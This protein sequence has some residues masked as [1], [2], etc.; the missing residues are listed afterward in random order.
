MGISATDWLALSQMVEVLKP[1]L[2]TT[3]ILCGYM[4]S[5]GQVIPLIHALDASLETAV[6]PG[7]SLLP[8]TRALVKRLQAGLQKRLHPVYSD[9]AYRMPCLCDP[10]IKGRLGSTHLKPQ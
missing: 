8:R 6:A 3:D 9:R 1:F 10:R 2:E 5:L 7:S 4:A